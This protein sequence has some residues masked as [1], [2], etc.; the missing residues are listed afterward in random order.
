MSAKP[1]KQAQDSAAPNCGRNTGVIFDIKRYAT[2]DGPGIR[3][4]VFF[5]GC[6]LA[7]GWCHN[8]ESLVMEPQGVYHRERCIGC[9]ECI[10]A[11]PQ[12]AL[13]LTPGGVVTAA[14][15]CRHCGTCARACPAEAREFAGWCES[16]EHLMKMI[17]KDVLFYDQSGG[18]VTFSGGEPL[19]Q[20][21]FLLELLEACGRRAIHRA[22]DTTGYADT[23]LLMAVAR[24]T[25]LF[26]YDLKLMDPV[27][28]QNY[29]GVSNRQILDNLQRLARERAVITIRIPLIPGIN[30]DAAN[31]DATGDFVAALPGVRQVDILPYHNSARH[32]YQKFGVAR[33]LGEIAP[34]LKEQIDR[35]ARQLARFGLKINIGG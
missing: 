1:V 24:R 25:D 33:R 18:G 11:C 17:E 26:L 32:K 9:G 20:P 13:A 30:D 3:T 5:K 29:T 35:V 7:C 34:P 31:I 22:V 21:D 10:R 14:A 28:H 27:K 19:R 6:P 16:V 4:T 12:G 23:D 2:H 15:R 8:P